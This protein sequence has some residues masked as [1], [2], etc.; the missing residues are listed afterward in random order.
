[1][2][3]REGG[4]NVRVISPGESRSGLFFTTWKYLWLS[5]LVLWTAVSE[6][7]DLVHAHWVLPSGLFGAFLAAIR[8][9]P[10]IV[11]SHGAFTNTF[12]QK[13]IVMRILVKWVL[14]RADKII[15]VGKEQQKKIE[16][17]VDLPAGS[18]TSI[19]MGVLIPKAAISK[20]QA[21]HQL[22]LSQE[23]NIIL[24][25]GNLL[26][27]KGPDL[28]IQAVA[29]IK[30]SADFQVYIGGQGPESV[31]LE[32]QINK[33]E[34]EGVIEMIGSVF[35]ED[36]K[37]W[38]SA[39]DICV[40]PSRTEPFGLV[41]IEALACGT[42]V[43]A[44]QVGGLTESIKDGY[45]GLLFPVGNYKALAGCIQVILTDGA[46]L[47]NMA[48]VAKESVMQYDMRLQANKVMGIYREFEQD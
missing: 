4:L 21:R 44:A 46:L 3:H 14:G 11:T 6:P 34:L 16:E 38:M 43:I 18:V 41:A 32:D 37:T 30:D 35:P 47:D 36:V 23:K 1:M 42:P 28:L 10:F 31:K 20:V 19:S 25:I 45:N 17:I 8:R 22:G 2:I 40:V 39:A 48:K 15:A 24:F 5:F 12:N 26:K 9:S 29:E 33:L 27:R 7:I 13:N